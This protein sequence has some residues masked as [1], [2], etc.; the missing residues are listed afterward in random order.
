MNIF[1]V[2][3]SLDNKEKLNLN[4]KT[5]FRHVEWVYENLKANS[6]TIHESIHPLIF[7]DTHTPAM[8]LSPALRAIPQNHRSLPHFYCPD[9]HSQMTKINSWGLL[10]LRHLCQEQHLLSRTKTRLHF[11]RM[12]FFANETMRPGH[13][14]YT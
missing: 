5:E 13:C 12:D 4:H 1:T 8:H 9:V 2:R 11:K 10:T 14:F 6:Q 3:R 7:Q